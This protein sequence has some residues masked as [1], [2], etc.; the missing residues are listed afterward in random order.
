LDEPIS[1]K[2]PSFLNVMNFYRT[3]V[4]QNMQGKVNLNQPIKVWTDIC[5]I[6]ATPQYPHAQENNI[7]EDFEDP[8][9]PKATPVFVQLENGKRALTT[10]DN[11]PQ[12]LKLQM[13][14]SSKKLFKKMQRSNKKLRK[15]LGGNRRATSISKPKPR[16][17]PVTTATFAKNYF[18]EDLNNQHNDS[19][20]EIELMLDNPKKKFFNNNRRDII[21]STNPQEAPKLI[22]PAVSNHYKVNPFVKKILL[23]KENRTSPRH[24]LLDSMSM[25]IEKP[26]LP[27]IEEDSIKPTYNFTIPEEQLFKNQ[28]PIFH[29]SSSEIVN[30]SKESSQI[31]SFANLSSTSREEEVDLLKNNDNNHQI[32]SGFPQITNKSNNDSSS[33]NSDQTLSKESIS[34]DSQSSDSLFKP[35]NLPTKKST[36]TTEDPFMK[37]SEPNLAN[38]MEFAVPQ[39]VVQPEV[40]HQN[41]EERV[42][43]VVDDNIKVRK[44]SSR[45]RIDDDDED[46]MRNS[47]KKFHHTPGFGSKMISPFIFE[48][49]KYREK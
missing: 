21:K 3:N 26:E 19:D 10:E 18:K 37:N 25:E 34:I 46:V 23:N 47:G 5:E 32:F 1:S 45:L 24:L 6:K 4:F 20:D 33:S 12:A 9:N 39:A 28:K 22:L 35:R 11:S 30:N 2:K 31:F 40:N 16:K 48:A 17:A 14:Q 27:F 8:I 49:G 36:A 7:S 43:A 29:F 15:P 38:S 42:L 13:L 44:I 41:K